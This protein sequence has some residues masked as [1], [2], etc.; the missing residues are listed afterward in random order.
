VYSY[1]QCN[2][3]AISSAIN[4]HDTAISDTVYFGVPKD[5]SNYDGI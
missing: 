1:I 4:A 3:S 2:S 5:Y